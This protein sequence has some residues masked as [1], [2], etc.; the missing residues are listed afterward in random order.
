MG[1]LFTLDASTKS[2][3][4]DALD[5]L[6]TEFGKDCELV[7]PARW[8]PCSCKADPIGRK[9]GDYWR[10]GGPVPINSVCPLCD[11]TNKR[12]DVKTE[13]LH[14]LC[15]WDTRKFSIPV[16]TVDVTLPYSRLQTKGYLSDAP[17]IIMADHLIVQIPVEGI[18]RKKFRRLSD[19]GDPSN[20][21]QN[22]YAITIWEQIA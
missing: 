21:I 4:Q 15:Q 19:P 17:K 11:G 18:I 6:I 1:K 7:Y 22:R 13:V 16:P 5:D 2:I 12:A 3:I 14:L 20:I 8:V 9:P 10:T